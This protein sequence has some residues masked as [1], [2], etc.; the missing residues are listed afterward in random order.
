MALILRDFECS[1]CGHKF[2]DLVDS[3]N[4]TYCPNC[5]STNVQVLL[6]APN[7]NTLNLLSQPE[8]KKKMIKRSA[9]HTKREVLK[10]PEKYKVKG[11]KK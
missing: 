4:T 7:L 10:E 2:E 6:S 8:L 11:V 9:D 5:A 1:T 3:S